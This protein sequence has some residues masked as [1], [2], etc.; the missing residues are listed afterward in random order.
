MRRSSPFLII[1]FFLISTLFLAAG[2]EKKGEDVV[3]TA[4]VG[5]PAPHFSLT[6]TQGRIWSLSDLRG[7]VV[8]VNFWATWCP[9]CRE[10]M[11]SMETLN[12]M[13]AGKSFKMLT[14][15]SND[16]PDMADRFVKTVGGTFPV[17]L[18]PDSAIG[19]AYGLTGVPETY[20][21][22]K[23][24]IL[25]EKFLGPRPWDSEGALNMIRQYL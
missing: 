23:Q 5:K 15:L 2:C 12:K 17:L 14:I 13:M 22:D 25:R 21:V 1:L 16:D 9:P 19:T 24:G 4:T 20:I 10:E 3:L 11:P 8:F 18:D 7:Q 6:D